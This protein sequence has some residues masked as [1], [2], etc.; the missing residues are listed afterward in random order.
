[1]SVQLVKGS[2]RLGREH[3]DA[4][5]EWL[6]GQM[7]RGGARKTGAKGEAEAIKRSQIAACEAVY[8]ARR[9]L[10]QTTVA[11]DSEALAAGF[12]ARREERD[13]YSNRKG[14]D[15]L[16]GAVAAWLLPPRGRAE[17][18]RWRERKRR[19]QAG[20]S[21]LFLPEEWPSLSADNAK[22]LARA[23][24]AVDL[25]ADRDGQVLLAA[26]SASTS[27]EVRRARLRFNRAMSKALHLNGRLVIATLAKFHVGEGMSISTS[28][29]LVAGHDGLHRGLLDYDPAVALPSTH[30]V[31]WIAQRMRRCLETA[32]IIHVPPHVRDA[33]SRVRRAG[34]DPAEVLF[35]ADRIEAGADAEEVRPLV[36]SMVDAIEAATLAEARKLRRRLE[37]DPGGA[38]KI[39][40]KIEACARRLAALKACSLRLGPSLTIRRVIFPRLAPLRPLQ[41]RLR[42]VAPFLGD[43]LLE[44]AMEPLA[45]A[46][47]LKTA[48]MLA[49]LRSSPTHLDSLD[50]RGRGGDDEEGEPI[51]L[52]AHEVDPAEEYEAAMLL[53]TVRHGLASMAE[54]GD[55]GRERAEVVRRLYGLQGPEETLLDIVR[56][57]LQSTGRKVSRGTVTALRDEGEAWLR[58][59]VGH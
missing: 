48:S 17:R 51:Q 25:I 8:V 41:A 49:A 55:R 54:E 31:T 53:S 18:A 14:I 58:G 20:Q 47:G 52:V 35:L 11:Y 37:R 9:A 32:S 23:W 28:D 21:I 6:I 27:P 57:G 45:R 38:S 4:S 22:A 10:W 59:A 3:D 26:S 56:T 50:R 30:L 39:K 24:P 29:L 15:N 7:A 43:A 13:D 12:L 34:V 46:T 5:T 2:G 40:P 44:A 36:E 1:M 19:E 33:T 42:C 16:R